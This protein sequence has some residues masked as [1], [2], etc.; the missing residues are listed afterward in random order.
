MDT[1]LYVALSHQQ[2]MARRLDVIANNIAN[3]NTNGFY[4]EQIMF[5]THLQ[6]MQG[7]TKGHSKE[8][9]YVIDQGLAHS[10][11]PGKIESTG[12]VFDVAISGQGFFAVQG[13]T[14]GIRY[15]R[16]G[17]FRLN[18]DGELSLSSGERV[19]DVND[20][21]II[22]GPGDTNPVF[23]DNG[24][25]VSDFGLVGQVNV[26]TFDDLSQLRKI[27]DTQYRTTQPAIG[28]ENFK[29]NQGMLELSNVNPIKEITEMIKVSRSYQTVAKLLDDYQQMRTR[30]IRDLGSIR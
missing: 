23:A 24:E 6:K 29:L 5:Q 18:D 12:N 30:A 19:L 9:A 28:A 22:F 27:G 17:H 25:I 16:N 3:M 14:G 10:F 2:A 8:I 4:K 13:D 15:T 7:Q 21:P 20:T 1:T 26:V 11:L